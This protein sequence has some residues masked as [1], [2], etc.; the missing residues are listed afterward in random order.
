MV[1]IVQR[2]VRGVRPFML[3][4]FCLVNLQPDTA[5]F[6]N[7]AFLPWCCCHPRASVKIA[8]GLKT[9][10]LYPNNQM[11]KKTL[12]NVYDFD[13]TLIRLIFLNHRC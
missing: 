2:L 1:P 9:S 6:S 5:F 12:Y 8:I 11:P 10:I 4:T 3:K 7:P 13:K